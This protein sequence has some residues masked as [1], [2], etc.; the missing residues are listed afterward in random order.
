MLT[1]SIHQNEISEIC[2][3][4]ASNISEEPYDNNWNISC[5]ISK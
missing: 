3:G 4:F 5:K 1:H 2:G